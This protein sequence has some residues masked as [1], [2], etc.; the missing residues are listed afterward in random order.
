MF[1]I[2]SIDLFATASL[3]STVSASTGS[4]TASRSCLSSDSADC[5]PDLRNDTRIPLF[6]VSTRENMQSRG[7]N[8]C[9]CERAT[10]ITSLAAWG[11]SEA[12]AQTNFDSIGLFRLLI[13]LPV[14][15]HY[16]WQWMKTF[17][18]ESGSLSNYAS[19][20][21]IITRA[22]FFVLRVKFHSSHLLLGMMT[23]P[24]GCGSTCMFFV[25][26]RIDDTLDFM[27]SDLKIQLGIG[28]WDLS[29]ALPICFARAC[30][31]PASLDEYI[32]LSGTAATKPQ[33][34]IMNYLE[35]ITFLSSTGSRVGRRE[36]KVEEREVK[37]C[38]LPK[39]IAL[40]QPSARVLPAFLEKDHWFPFE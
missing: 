17:A 12:T 5:Q 23:Q 7:E 4:H 25:R 20:I 6:C 15:R 34:Q 31:A 18:I 29:K 19:H 14:V 3:V 33:P 10:M 30:Y 35:N 40:R 13:A 21:P 24:E 38:A 11:I 37:R 1:L 16:Y 28:N 32:N 2:D 27:T 36:Q 39:L 22:A 26:R 8:N 9:R